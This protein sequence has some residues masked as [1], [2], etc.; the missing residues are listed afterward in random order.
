MKIKKR[1]KKRKRKSR[2]R[3]AV[4]TRKKREGVVVGAPYVVPAGGS[5]ALMLA[6]TV[7]NVL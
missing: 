6:T 1:K 7:A 2:E 4:E 3:K 5:I